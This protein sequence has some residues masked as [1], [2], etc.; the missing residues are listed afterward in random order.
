MAASLLLILVGCGSSART[1]C[2]DIYRAV[3]N[4][5]EIFVICPEVTS[6]SVDELRASVEAVFTKYVGPPDE[7]LLYYA[8]S[9]PASERGEYNA[10]YYTHSGSVSFYDEAGKTVREVVVHEW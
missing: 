5:S 7:T 3:P 8:E 2:S 4:K 6:L 10:S 1:P 9:I